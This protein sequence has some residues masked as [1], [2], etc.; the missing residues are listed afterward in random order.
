MEN[1]LNKSKKIS[2]TYIRTIDNINISKKG[3]RLGTFIWKTLL[4]KNYA[5][6]EFK[7]LQRGGGAEV[8]IEWNNKDLKKI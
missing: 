4:K 8:K 7:N 5:I 2:E 1:I 6:V 3:L